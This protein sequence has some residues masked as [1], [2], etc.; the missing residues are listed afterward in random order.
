MQ[1]PYVFLF[2]QNGPRKIAHGT[3]LLENVHK[4]SYP[5]CQRYISKED[6]PL[7]ELD[8]TEDWSVEII[9]WTDELGR[10][11]NLPRNKHIGWICGDAYVTKTFVNAESGQIIPTGIT[12][13][14]LKSIN[15]GIAKLCMSFR[16]LY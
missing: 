4:E 16:M 10:M 2:P 5:L 8:C 1:A 14:D 11:K 13:G 15:D 3:S 9:L 7:F 6:E 12:E